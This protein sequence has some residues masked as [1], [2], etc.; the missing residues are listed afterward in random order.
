MTYTGSLTASD[1]F[2]TLTGFSFE[3]PWDVMPPNYSMT[4][5]NAG[6][7]GL[8]FSIPS[9]TRA[10]LTLDTAS[11]PIFAGSDRVL[12]GRSVSTR[13]YGTCTPLP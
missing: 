7:D 10:C 6:Q 5:V 13:D 9:G 4:V 3:L 12:M 11:L 8:D 1:R 2:T